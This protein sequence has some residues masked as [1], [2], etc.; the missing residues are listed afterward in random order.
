[1][2]TLYIVGNGFDLHHGLPTTY[3]GFSEY[4]KREHPAIYD[5]LNHVISY[6]FTDD[7][8]WN[9]FEENLSFID[10]SYL[11]DHINEYIPCPASDDYYKDLGACTLEAQRM[12]GYLTH[13]LRNAFAKYI[14][15]ADSHHAGKEYLINLDLDGFY[16]SFNYTRTLEKYYGISADNILYLH[17]T[18]DDKENIILGHAV[19]PETFREEQDDE[20]PPMGLTTEQLEQ[21]REYKSDQ[22]I[23]FLDEA[24]EELFSYYDRTFK[25]VSGIIKNHSSLFSRLV[26]LKHIYILGHS[27]S[28]VDIEYF[29]AIKE[30]VP[31]YCQWYVSYYGANEKAKFEATLSWLGIPEHNYTLFELVSLRSGK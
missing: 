4:L 23:P 22:E 1:L 25:N 10:I 20:S 14:R 9:R 7:D 28:D 24:R 27:M 5:I 13:D 3:R 30:R 12:V 17:G 15:K 16:I 18:H 26:E 31:Q 19:D 29:E 11:E 6:H 8:L 21:W 2:E